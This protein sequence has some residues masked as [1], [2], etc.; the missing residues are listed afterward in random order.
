MYPDMSYTKK[1][2][3]WRIAIFRHQ[4]LASQT[5]LLLDSY[6]THLLSMQVGC[7]QVNEAIRTTINFFGNL[8]LS[9]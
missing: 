5:I 8:L 4:L 6:D 9:I 7:A 1:N 2:T 3:Q